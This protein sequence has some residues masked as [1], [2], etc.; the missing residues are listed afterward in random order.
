MA[1]AVRARVA[2]I[3]AGGIGGYAGALLAGQPDLDVVFC[4][5]QP[6]H[7]LVVTAPP[8]RMDVPVRSAVEPGQVGP[9]DVVLL[10]VK[11]QDT[12]AAQP[13]LE[14]L[15]G[16]QTTVAVLQNGVEHYA[17]LNPVVAGEQI[18]P[19]VVR[20][21][22]ER[23]A[24]ESIRL[25]LDGDLVL[26]D[27]GR[28]RRVVSIFDGTTLSASV[29]PDFDQVMWIK[30]A[31]NIA[32]NP[33]TT[34]FNL[35]VN[36]LATHPVASALLPLLIRECCAVAAAEGVGLS[37]DL[38]ARIPAQLAAMPASVTSSMYQDR[39]RGR[40]WSTARSPARWF[41]LVLDMGYRHRSTRPS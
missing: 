3:G 5:R 38:D 25:T 41:G 31:N 28:G 21:G 32:S 36:Q 7:R 19:V 17:R 24:R 13:W 12:V 4:V 11:A 10:A 37:A 14:R 33:I 26:P 18:V 27:T 1:G 20:F 22:A 29:T 30:L 8:G 2:V 15:V 35:S 34:I 9:V 39:R 40:H 23:V 16:P 6:I